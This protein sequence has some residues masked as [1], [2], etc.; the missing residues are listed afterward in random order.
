M[1]IY[2]RKGNIEQTTIGA[3]GTGK[4]NSM[5]KTIAILLVI[6]IAMTGIFAALVTND[7]KDS[8]LQIYTTVDQHTGFKVTQ[9]AAKSS[10]NFEAFLNMETADI[11][12]ADRDKGLQSK[13][14]ITAAN[15][16]ATAYKIGMK[17]R[18]MSGQS[19]DNNSKINYTVTVADQ[20]YD[21]KSPSTP[22][23]TVLS[24][25][26]DDHGMVVA[27]EPISV[28]LDASDYDDAK[29]DVYVGLITF[30]VTSN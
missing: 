20:S 26:G 21:T 27:S 4:E 23:V 7:S 5:K 22:A 29:P 9:S 25:Q 3:L 18:R 2:P 19:Q 13:A 17:A 12:E 6:T 11:I 14:Y 16:D 30:L 8:T 1:D 15:N 10:T 24:V 28:A